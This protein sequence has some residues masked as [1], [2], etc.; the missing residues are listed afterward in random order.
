MRNDNLYPLILKIIL[1][2]GMSAVALWAMIILIGMEEYWLV[3]ALAAGVLCINFVFLSRRAYPFRYI[4]PGLIF[5]V[6]MVIFPLVYTVRIAFT[7]FGTGHFLTKRR[8]IEILEG[9]YYRPQD[10]VRYTFQAFQN[11]AGALRVI[12]TTIDGDSFISDAEQLIAVDLSQVRFIDDNNDGLIDRFD[13]YR[14]LTRMEIFRNLAALERL[15]LSKDEYIVKMTSPAEF[16]RF[17]Q[18]FRYDPIE[19][20]MIDLKTGTIY[21]P[22]YGIFTSAAG[23]RLTPGFKADI[24]W[25]HFREILHNPAISRPFFRV[26]YWTFLFAGLSVVT[27]FALGLFLALTFNDPLLG[28]KKFYRSILIIPWAIPG[29]ISVLIW[30]GLFNTE[31]GIINQLIGHRIPWFQ[32]PFLARTALILVNLWLGFPFMMT[33]SL[34]ALQSI[35][36][37]LHEAAYVDGASPWQRFHS[38]TFP[39]LM[40]SLAPLL[41]GSFAFNF[42]NFALVFL[43]TGGGPHIP[44]MPGVAGATDI[45]ISYTYKLAFGGGGWGIQYGLASAVSIII[46]LIIGTISLI[47]FKLSGTF[48]EVTIDV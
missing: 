6:A 13:G 23:E 48:K 40:V 14:R 15:R 5:F 19:E 46:A 8:A 10:P 4:L 32:D 47:N 9:R 18:R 42:N 17:H 45:L 43:L 33:I 37:E 16:T 30:A 34:G 7:N 1:L 31:V 28:G 39:L 29:F 11:E 12:L 35:P 36:H 27:T 2:S 44:G 26:F 21:R 25:R 3:G 20:V 22:Q 41:V 38:I 24:G